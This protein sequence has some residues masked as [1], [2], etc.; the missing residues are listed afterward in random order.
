MDLGVTNVPFTVRNMEPRRWKSIDRPWVYAV[1]VLSALV[2]YSLLLF[3]DSYVSHALMS[4]RETLIQVGYLGLR[5]SL[6]DAIPIESLALK[7]VILAVLSVALVA[8][9]TRLTLW[10]N[11]QI[12]KMDSDAN[13]P[14]ASQTKSFVQRVDA[15]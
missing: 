2:L 4:L 1:A 6:L 3:E 8:C 9:A 5:V 14:T 11:E 13:T 7:L 12:E 10:T 15:E